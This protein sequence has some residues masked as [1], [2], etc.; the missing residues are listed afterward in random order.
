MLELRESDLP[1]SFYSLLHPDD[2]LCLAE[3][4]KEGE[5]LVAA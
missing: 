1:L 3:A 2:G 4:H 5:C